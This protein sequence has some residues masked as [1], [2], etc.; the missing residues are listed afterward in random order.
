MKKYSYLIVMETDTPED[1]EDVIQNEFVRLAYHRNKIILY[2]CESG[3]RLLSKKV[4]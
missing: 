4:D 1:L 2:R 3:F